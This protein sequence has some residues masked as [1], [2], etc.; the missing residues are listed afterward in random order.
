MAFAW[1]VWLVLAAIFIG[2]EAMTPGFFLLWF[3]VGALAAAVLALAGIGGIGAQIIVFLVVSV[4]LLITSRNVIERFFHRNTSENHLKTGVETLVGQIATVVEASD[5]V[6]N[7]AAVRVYGSVWTAFPNEGEPPLQVGE[8]VAVDRI[9][10]NTLYVR[11]RTTRQHLFSE[12]S[13]NA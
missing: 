5:G 13:E 12:T 1:I 3:G 2:I 8:S 6:L 10:G 9:D 11:R 7:Q 4:L